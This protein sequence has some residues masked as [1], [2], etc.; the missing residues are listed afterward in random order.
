[1]NVTDADFLRRVYDIALVTHAVDERLWILTRQG[2]A[3]FVLTTQ[4]PRGRADRKRARDA[5]RGRLGLAVL[6]RPRG[7]SR[8]RGDAL[9]AVPRRLARA[10]DPHSGGRQLTAHLSS[11]SLR[12][13]SVS[14]E[15]GAHL[16]HAVGA[17]Y[18]AV[19][20]GEDSVRDVLLRRWRGVRGRDS[21]GDE[22]RRRAQAARRL[23]LREQRLHDQRPAGTAD[24]HR[25]SSRS[26]LP[27][28]AS[29]GPPST[30]ATQKPCAA[31][32]SRRSPAPEQERG[33]RLSTCE[34]RASL[35][36]RPKTTTPIATP[37]RRLPQRASIRSL[38]S[39]RL[40]ELGALDVDEDDVARKTIEDDVLTAAE[41]AFARPEPTAD[42][43]RRWLYADG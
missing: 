11:K 33:R 31:R 17:A 38:D 30:D 29:Q 42:R 23:P 14:S 35:P 19:V 43:A 25:L 13:G 27:G 6:P 41:A 2:R 37:R 8:P 5:T 16:P 4:R 24:A 7:G 28:M 20:K 34:C 40:I 36:T 3:G 22:P 32:L 12:I 21:R 18:T 1:M 26:A 9:R 15:V 39:T 10:D